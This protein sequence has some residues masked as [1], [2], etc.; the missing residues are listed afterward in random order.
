MKKIGLLFITLATL[1][2]CA[3]GPLVVHETGRTVG[4]SN[5]E[6]IV[7]YGLSS[8]VA[9]WNYGV[10]PNLD[11]AV[12]LEALSLGVKLKYAF[13]N[14]VEKGWS[15]AAAIGTGVSIG[16]RHY[17]ADVITS[18]LTG[19]W[20]PY[21]ALRVVRVKTDPLDFKN[22]DTGNVDFTVDAYQYNYGQYILGVRYWFNP[23]WLFSLEGSALFSMSSS[24]KIGSSSLVGASF[25]YRF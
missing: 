9:K 13:I 17:Y 12:Q 22:E 10:N 4:A 23:N 7:G 1:S 5:H 3:V 19:S 6:V 8:Y 20:E 2:G 15:L 21:T 16:G 25:G 11:F 18:Y 24:V 14:N